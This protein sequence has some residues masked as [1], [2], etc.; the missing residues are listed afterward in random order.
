MTQTAP[1]PDV[2]HGPTAC[3]VP[4]LLTGD[5]Y[6]L[7]EVQS[8]VVFQ[9]VGQ[10]D[11]KDYMTT[12]PARAMAWHMRDVA[13][14]VK[15]TPNTVPSWFLPKATL[16]TYMDRALPVYIAAGPNKPPGTWQNRF[17]LITGSV[18]SQGEIS[19]FMEEYFMNVLLLIVRLGFTAWQPMVDWK[20]QGVIDRTNG[21]SGYNRSIPCQYIIQVYPG[22]TTGPLFADWAS[23]FAFMSSPRGYGGGI[24]YFPNDPTQAHL[25]FNNPGLNVQ[26][27]EKTICALTM[28]MQQGLRPS[29]VTPCYNW[30][31]AEMAQHRGTLQWNVNLAKHI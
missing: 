16:Q 19:G 28:A 25:A 5:P 23:M 14:A 17:K 30:L 20:L 29:D 4:F 11:Y 27:D 7:E 13:Y 24:Y 18:N 22:N 26:Y 12:G 6:Y 8:L 2:A 21:T 31:L 3:Y 10:S 1:M 15:A 9:Y